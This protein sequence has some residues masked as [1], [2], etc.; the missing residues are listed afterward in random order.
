MFLQSLL[1]VKW[2]KKVCMKE[3]KK[4][5]SKLVYK[6]C[7]TFNFQTN[8]IRTNSFRTNDFRT[9]CFTQSGTLGNL[10]VISF[11]WKVGRVFRSREINIIIIS[12]ETLTDRETQTC[13]SIRWQRS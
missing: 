2:S 12:I 6:S 5:S 7:L 3:E 1:K 9:N 8:C 4:I 10:K 13:H 11:L